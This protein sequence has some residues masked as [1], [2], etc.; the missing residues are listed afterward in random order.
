VLAVAALAAVLLLARDGDDES[1]ERRAAV[2]AYI[3]QVNTTQQALIVELERVSTTYRQL[4]L[5]P[6]EDPRQLRRV[7]S[8]ARTL[9]GLRSRLAGL[10][11][12]TEVQAL[13]SRLLRLVDLQIAMADEVAGMVEYLPLQA[14]EARTLASSTRRLRDELGDAKTVEAQ[15][16]VFTA[17]EDALRPSVARLRS[18]IAPAIFEPSRKG[19]VARL[20]RLLSLSRQVRAALEKQDAK[21]IDK[22][23]ARFVQTS[24]SV[25]TTKAEREA[26]VAFNKRLSAI[27]KARS[28]VA[29]ERVRLDLELR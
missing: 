5:K 11:A 25:G 28:A 15:R 16:R 26:V 17:Y 19:E 22:L 20:T 8:A 2:S 7:E 10:V 4:R 6:D 18:G 21:E 1:E 14:R 3:V 12:P 23:F 27:S 24:A 29:A 13:R 9:R